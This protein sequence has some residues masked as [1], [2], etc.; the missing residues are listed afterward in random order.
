MASAQPAGVQR[1]TASAA[2]RFAARRPQPTLRARVAHRSGVARAGI[3]AFLVAGLPVAVLEADSPVAAFGDSRSERPD[4]VLFQYA[5]GEGA[6]ACRILDSLVPRP[7]IVALVD[8]PARVAAADC[9]A[10]GADAAIA[11]DTIS[12]DSLVLAVEHALAGTGPVAIGFPR[13]PDPEAAQPSGPLAGLTR[14]ERELLYLIGE[15]LSNREIAALLTLSA[16]TVENH[17]ASLARKLDTTSRAGLMRLALE[18][19]A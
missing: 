14:R 3:S 18:A 9:H 11:I 15:G 19:G 13:R 2:V 7:A 8:D 6:Y 17:R 12:H 1:P 4:L 10:A 5:T 16:K